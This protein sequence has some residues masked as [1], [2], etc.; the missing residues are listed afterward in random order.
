M[1]S[2]NCR[3]CSATDIRGRCVPTRVGKINQDAWKVCPMKVDTA[4][5]LLE[6]DDDFSNEI[7]TYL[8]DVNSQRSAAT[9]SKPLTVLF[10]IGGM[11]STECYM[12]FS[13]RDK[14]NQERCHIFSIIHGWGQKWGLSPEECL[15][16]IRRYINSVRG[17]D[18]E[19]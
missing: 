5:W 6:N 11:D 18:A 3:C 12:A 19:E 16:L 9:I 2:I 7:D 1:T 13:D 14:N 10:L 4:L 8:S 17:Q 15:E